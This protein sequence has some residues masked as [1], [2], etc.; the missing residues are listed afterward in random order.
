MKV[1]NNWTKPL[2]SVTKQLYYDVYITLMILV[3]L[4]HTVAGHT[5]DQSKN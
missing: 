4:I 2:N 1:L 3:K 5:D